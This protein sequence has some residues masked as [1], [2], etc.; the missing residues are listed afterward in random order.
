MAAVIRYPYHPATKY[1]FHEEETDAIVRT[2]SCHRKDFDLAE[3]WFSPRKHDDIRSS[4]ATP[5]PR[6]PDVGLSSLDRLPLELLRDVLSRLDMHSLFQIRQTSLRSR[7]AVDS[8][9]EYQMIVLHG[10]NL[11]CALL[12]TQLASDISLLDFYDVLCTKTC[13]IFGQFGGFVSLLSWARCCFRCITKSVPRVRVRTFAGVQKQFRLTQTGREQLRSIKTLPGTYTMSRSEYE[14]GITI[15][16]HQQALLISQEPLYALKRAGPPNRRLR[17]PKFNYMGSCALP[18]YD[19]FTGNV[20]HGMSCAAC[21]LDKVYS[22]EG[23]LEHFKWCQ[24]AQ[25]L[26][27]SSG[28]GK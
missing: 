23:L 9:K 10:L 26:W 1:R 24:R 28:G 2:V 11:Y 15:V 21:E 3:I 6:S 13:S 20:E 7:E 25:V 12:R 16:S 18:Y 8:L 19:R 27:R 22:R 17:N 4:I 5:F 14:G